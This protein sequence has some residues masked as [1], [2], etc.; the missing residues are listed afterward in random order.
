MADAAPAARW[1][2]LAADMRFG[3]APRSGDETVRGRLDF[4]DFTAFAVPFLVCVPI[5][6]GG[7]LF[8]GEIVLLVLLPLLLL[9]RSPGAG[10]VP[11]VFVVLC[12]L[13]LYGQVVTDIYRGT[14]FADLARGW[15]KIVFTTSNF[16][17]IYLMIDGR[18]SRLRL[19]GWGV[20]AGGIAQFLI[21]PNV[22]SSADSWKFG[23]GGGTT[24]AIVMLASA[25]R[26]RR[27]PLIA[28]ALLCV[29]SVLNLKADF[30]SLAG[31]CFLAMCLLV[32]NGFRGGHPSVRP[33]VTPARLILMLGAVAL[34]TMAF[35]GA[36]GRLAS[37]GRLG[38]TAAVK[39]T[40]QAD[41]TSGELALF[42]TGRPEIY[43]SSRAVRDSPL[44]GHGSWAKDPKYVQM[45]RDRGLYLSPAL[46]AAPLIPT[47]SHLMGA[48]VDA[49]IFG[50]PVWLWVLLLALRVV[51][52]APRLRHPLA[53]LALFAGLTLLWDV[54]FSPYGAQERVVL[55]FF[56][57]LLL[58]VWRH[59][60]APRDDA[61]DTQ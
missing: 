17:A 2:T 52:S 57:V 18:T 46:L 35:L 11:A 12:C 61:V 43:V 8:L 27:L 6:F 24:L 1:P 41:A 23:I 56:V 26:A 58:D 31:I 15:S 39:Y 59:A 19:F 30:R 40:V 20:A 53:P 38:T 60:K 3:S 32:V 36:Y 16:V 25:E 44:L 28:P 37:S 21:S 4:L 14:E 47:H 45:L 51:L 49:G 5:T 10:A 22:Y 34:A 50:V 33:A 54:I 7:R 55:P 29:A 42:S 9:R 13:W 48:W